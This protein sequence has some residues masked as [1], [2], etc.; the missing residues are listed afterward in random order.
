MRVNKQFPV[1]S[2]VAYFSPPTIKVMETSNY[3]LTHII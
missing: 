1:T 3:L 2:I